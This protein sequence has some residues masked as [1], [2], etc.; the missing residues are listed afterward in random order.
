M[1]AP[2]DIHI[3]GDLLLTLRNGNGCLFEHRKTQSCGDRLVGHTDNH[4]GHPI[5]FGNN[6]TGFQIH[7][8]N[9]PFREFHLVEGDRER[10]SPGERRVLSGPM[11][12][13]KNQ[14]PFYSPKY[15]TQHGFP[16]PHGAGATTFSGNILVYM[17][18][19]DLQAGSV[20]LTTPDGVRRNGLNRCCSQ[21]SCP[22]S[23][24]ILCPRV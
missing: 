9:S 11:S 20:K 18:R 16:D 14:V 13:I 5:L 3:I 17:A 6:H 10:Q 7:E 8:F 12:K 2:A 22:I 23:C 21:M 1:R 24:K 15:G 19:C 4:A